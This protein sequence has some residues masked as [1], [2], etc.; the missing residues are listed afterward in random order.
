MKSSEQINEI[1]TALAAFQGEIDTVIKDANNPHFRSRYASFAACRHAAG[2]GLAKNGLSVVQG[3]LTD[4]QKIEA[5]V[6]TT[7]L[8]KSGQW[9]ENE[10]WAKPMTLKDGTIAPCTP[11]NVGAIGSYLRRTEY[12]AIIGLVADDDDDG[13]QSEVLDGP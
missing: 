2:P 9:I 6:R 7:L 12:C 1:A 5:G 13:E 10:V 11:Q 4:L 3:V 8:H